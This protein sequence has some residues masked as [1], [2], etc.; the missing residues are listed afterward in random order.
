MNG[1]YLRAQ[2]LSSYAL[3]YRLIKC[4]HNQLC[5]SQCLRLLRNVS[6]F[7]PI[8]Q[9]LINNN[10]KSPARSAT[11]DEHDSSKCM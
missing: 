3:I 10:A 5:Q 11:Y 8:A 9:H 2:T 6:K 4:S 7:F 1:I